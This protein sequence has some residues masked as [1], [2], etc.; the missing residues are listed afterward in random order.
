MNALFSIMTLY[1]YDNT[2]FD[3]LKLPTGVV[4]ED[5]VNNLLLE[6]AELEI[7]YPNPIV[8][9]TAIGMWSSKELSVWDKLYKSTTQE[10]NPIWNQFRTEE[11]TDTETRALSATDNESRDLTGTDNETRDLGG[12]TTKNSTT[13]GSTTNNGTDTTKEYVSGF[14]S[15]TPALSKQNEQ[16]LGTGNTVS[17]T[18]KGTDTTSDTG[19]VNK[20]STD[21]GNVNRSK[22]DTGTVTNAHT[23]KYEGHTG[24]VPV[25]KLLDMERETVKFNVIDYIIDSFK[26]RFCI[27]VY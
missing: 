18:I 20:N 5:V 11:Y 17:G 4:K 21:K 10:Y 12:T 8:M 9:K 26:N 27:Q 22:T 15:D 7:I 24:I 3:D 19:T 16:T 13:T 6:L 25:Q 2:I 1:N 14:N 23:A